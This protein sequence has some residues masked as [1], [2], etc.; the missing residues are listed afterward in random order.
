VIPFADL[1]KAWMAAKD[2]HTAI[3]FVARDD[4]TLYSF[5][6]DADQIAHTVRQGESISGFKA[7][8]DV[9]ADSVVKISLESRGEVWRRL[10]SAGFD[11]VVTSIQKEDDP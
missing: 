4:G 10:V 7:F 8:S 9:S 5:F 2:R 3:I 6:V 11:M 1:K